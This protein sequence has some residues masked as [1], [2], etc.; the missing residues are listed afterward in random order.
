VESAAVSRARRSSVLP[1]RRGMD[2]GVIFSRDAC[3]STGEEGPAP[4][5]ARDFVLRVEGVCPWCPCTELGAL[6][7]P[8]AARRL[9]APEWLR[10]RTEADEA[11]LVRA[12]LGGAT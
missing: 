11:E 1:F 7:W 6:A 12:R 5:G 3:P 4:P 9:D 8:T 10:A 2:G